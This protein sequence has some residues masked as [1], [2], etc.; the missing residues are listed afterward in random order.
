MSKLSMIEAQQCHHGQLLQQILNAATKETDESFNLPEGVN[1]PVQN[2]AKLTDLEKTLENAN[3]AK[4]LVICYISS[5]CSC[6]IYLSRSIP[7]CFQLDASS[8]S[9]CAIITTLRDGKCLA[10]HRSKDKM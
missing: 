6:M 3:S 4:P 8:N 10:L 7:V 5:A 1:L 9:K 2:I